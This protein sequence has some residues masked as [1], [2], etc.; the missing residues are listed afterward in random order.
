MPISIT[1]TP[2]LTQSPLTSLGIPTPTT[3]ISALLVFSAVSFVLLLQIVT[4]PPAFN[5]SRAIGLP[6]MLE[7][8]TTTQSLPLTSQPIEASIVITPFGVQGRR[9]D[10]FC[11]NLPIFSLWKPSMSLFGDICSITLLESM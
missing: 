8:P 2:S 9:F 7:A 3:T 6:T 11:V 1:I 5:N 4:V 10:L